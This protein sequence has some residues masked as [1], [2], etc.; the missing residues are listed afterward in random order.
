MR[1]SIVCKRGREGNERIH[2]KFNLNGG[3]GVQ[4]T[5]FSHLDKF[6]ILG[7]QREGGV[8]FPLLPRITIH[9]GYWPTLL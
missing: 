9:H 5:L 4:V 3:G 8:T 2:V 7:V 1:L 6:L